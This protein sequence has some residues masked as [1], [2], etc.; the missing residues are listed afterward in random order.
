MPDLEKKGWE[1]AVV[2]PFINRIVS[3]AHVMWVVV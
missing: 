3:V 1:M 2:L